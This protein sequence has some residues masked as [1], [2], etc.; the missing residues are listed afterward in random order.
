MFLT[1][2][3][4]GLYLLLHRFKKLLMPRTIVNCTLQ[5]SVLKSSRGFLLATRVLHRLE[6]PSEAEARSYPTE[7]KIS[8]IYELPSYTR[9]DRKVQRYRPDQ[10]VQRFRPDRRAQRATR[11]EGPAETH[12]PKGRTVASSGVLARTVGRRRRD[13]YTLKEGFYFVILGYVMF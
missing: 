7:S 1:S 8:E 5:A 11:L 12:R 4:M 13:P 2:L 10:R 6:I 3:S 9:P